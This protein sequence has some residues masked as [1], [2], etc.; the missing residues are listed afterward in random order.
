MV[1]LSTGDAG[2]DSAAALVTYLTE[3]PDAGYAWRNRVG[4]VQVGTTVIVLQELDVQQEGSPAYLTDAE[5]QAVVATAVGR[6][7]ALSGG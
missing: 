5:W 2:D 1:A 3:G 4:V 7:E 6:V